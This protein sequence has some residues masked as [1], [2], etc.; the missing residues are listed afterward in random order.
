MSSHRWDLLRLWFYPRYGLPSVRRRGWPAPA[1]L[2]GLIQVAPILN[3]LRMKRNPF[4]AGI[5]LLLALVAP[6]QTPN[7]TLDQRS[8]LAHAKRF[9]RNGWTYLHAEGDAPTR[10]F[11]HGYLLAREIAETMRVHRTAWEYRSGVAWTWL[12]GR[13]GQLLTPKVDPENLAELD[14]IVAGMRAAGKE[15]SRDEMV[16]YNAQLEFEGYWWPLEKKHLGDTRPEP[17]QDRCSAFIATGSWTADHGIVMGHNTMFAYV[18]AVANVVLDL[19]PTQGQRL[20]MQTQPGFI[21]SGT[22][23][24]LTSAGLVGCE[25]TIGQFTGFDTNGIPEFVRM[26]RASQDAR[27]IQEWCDIVKRGNN[28]GYANAWLLGDIHSGQIARLELGL[29]YVG[30]ETTK[31]GYFAGSNVAENKALL[32]LETG[33]SETDIRLSA[34]ARRVRWKQLLPENKG[35]ITAELAEKFLADD[36]DVY[37]KK[38]NPGARTL[39]RHYELDRQEFGGPEPFEPN[40]TFDGKVVD[41]KLAEQMSF[42]ARWGAADG[43]PFYAAEFLREHPQYDWQQGL[44]KDRPSQPWAR[45]R[46]GE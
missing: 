46:A 5:L 31:D 36:Y 38:R 27:S 14:G 13:A 35:R 42:L 16:A 10:G 6:A 18:E 11:Q 15:T 37:L 19:E 4:I 1:S 25:T 7:L 24:F 12:V 44:L 22:D 41:S 32:R 17:A 2:P 43:R 33:R 3:M 29:K 45:F 20:L 8:W 34:P 39:C 21:H 30:F 28:G 9:E 23:F 26:R 40:G